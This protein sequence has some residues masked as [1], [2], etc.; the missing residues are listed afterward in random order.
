MAARLAVELAEVAYL[1]GDMAAA[2]RGANGAL[3]LAGPRPDAREVVLKARNTLGKI[4]LS[5]A[6]WDEAD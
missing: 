2:A 1:K 4:L 3:A 5:D 6:K